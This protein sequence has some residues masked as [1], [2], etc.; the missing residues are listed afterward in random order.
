MKA[1]PTRRDFLGVV[2]LALIHPNPGEPVGFSSDAAPSGPEFHGCLSDLALKV[3]LGAGWNIEIDAMIESLD[4]P[5]RW[6]L[7]EY[8]KVSMFC[9]ELLPVELAKRFR[10]AGVEAVCESGYWAG[11]G[12]Q[13]HGYFVEMALFHDKRRC[14]R[15]WQGF[16]NLPEEA[17]LEISEGAGE[18]MV[19][20]R[21]GYCLPGKVYFRRENLLASVLP[22]WAPDESAREFAVRVDRWIMDCLH[23]AS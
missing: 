22:V 18:A 6:V 11:S 3:P 20:S 12:D 15:A 1:K 19:V 21:G 5:Q 8:S 14:Q 10:A 17:G 9:A 23:D 13:K 7:G 4:E 16:E 2:G